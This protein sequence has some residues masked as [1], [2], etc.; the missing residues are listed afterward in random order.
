M[1]LNEF[2]TR[3]LNAIGIVDE[4]GS[5]HLSRVLGVDNLQPFMIGKKRVVLPTSEHLRDNSEGTIIYH[6]LSE[7]I[8]RGE[9]DMIKALRDTIMFKLTYNAVTLLSELGRV[10]ATDSEHKRLDANSSEYLKALREMDEK[11]F[12]FLKKVLRQIG[13]E[14]EKRLISISLRKAE[15][16]DGVRRAVKF[17]FPVMEALLENDKELL[18][19]K[20]P[21]KKCRQN[22]INLFEVVLGTDEERA[23][24]DFGSK[25][26]TAPY[27]H[28]L[29]SGFEK[30]AIRLN[31][32]ALKHKKLLGKDLFEE[33]LIDLSWTEAMDELGEL[34]KKV[35]PQEG[36]EGAIIV[37]APKERER[38]ADQLATRI[39]PPTREQSTE[40]APKRAAKVDLPWD[41]DEEAPSTTVRSDAPRR[42]GKSLD[43]YLGGG[44][45]DRDRDRGRGRDDRG[46][47]YDRDDRDDRGRSS[48]YG[49]DREERP[50][51][52]LGLEDDR[53]RDRG[54][55]FSERDYRRDERGSSRRDQ[56]PFGAG[57]NRGGF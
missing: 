34:R 7:N 25:N 48:R 36:N 6:P 38:V 14:P 28:A 17:K 24:Y 52:N 3:C 39:A 29:M 33:M 55:R 4:T 50:R 32:I 56:R 1:D 5:G 49:R 16:T 15:E 20:Y 46:S 8:T 41:D 19:F 47:R 12:E 22:L 43:D 18:G 31:G 54:S 51:F 13:S 26:L 2:N 45:D 42:E 35:P 40:R 23:E 57:H 11:T 21:S 53:D 9:S 27:F 37:A 30:V 44:R 10:A